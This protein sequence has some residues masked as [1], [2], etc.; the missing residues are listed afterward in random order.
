LN[1]VSF[2][3]RTEGPALSIFGIDQIID[4]AVPPAAVSQFSGEDDVNKRLPAFS[5]FSPVH[6]DRM[7]SR[8]KKEIKQ[9]IFDTAD[10]DMPSLHDDCSYG[11]FEKLS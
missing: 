8:S 3:Y 5:P 7:G 11:D 4:R 9:L 10:Q 1:G 2:R 6:L